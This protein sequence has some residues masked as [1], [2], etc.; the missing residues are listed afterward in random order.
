[1]AVF[2]AATDILNLIENGNI[3]IA[4]TW[5]VFPIFYAWGLRTC[6]DKTVGCFRYCFVSFLGI[7]MG[8]TRSKKKERKKEKNRIEKN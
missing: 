7:M 1:M 4:K 3:K 8:K 2:L 5:P 6:C